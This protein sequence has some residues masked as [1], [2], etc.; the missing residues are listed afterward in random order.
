MSGGWAVRRGRWPEHMCWLASDSNDNVVDRAFTQEA[1]SVCGTNIVVKAGEWWLQSNS[2]S[3]QGQAQG[4]H[5]QRFSDLVRT[6]LP[7]ASVWI[8]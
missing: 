6:E 3:G 1:Q 8:T 7:G 4:S 2:S 5:F